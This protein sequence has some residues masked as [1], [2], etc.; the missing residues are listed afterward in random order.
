MKKEEKAQI[1]QDVLERL[2]GEDVANN[3]R[4]R[5]MSYYAR[6]VG[7]ADWLATNPSK[8]EIMRAIHRAKDKRVMA[9]PG[10]LVNLKK[11]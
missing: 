3:H 6:W 5:K 4:I 11:H 2:K 9:T 10:S 7:I 8:R 1:K